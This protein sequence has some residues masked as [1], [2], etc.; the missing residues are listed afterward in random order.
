MLGQKLQNAGNIGQEPHVK[1]AVGFVKHHNFD[2]RQ[3][4]RALLHMVEQPTRRCR[5][6]LHAAPEH[7][8][9]RPNIDA[10]INH[11]G[12]QRR[13]GTVFNE[14]VGNLIRKFARGSQNECPNRMASR[15]HRSIRLGQNARN[16]RQS[17]ACCLPCPGLCRAH[18]I[19]SHEH[20]R[21]SFFLNRRWLGVAHTLNGRK[22]AGIET[23][24]IERRH[25]NILGRENAG[26]AKPQNSGHTRNRL[27]H[28]TSKRPE[29]DAEG[30]PRSEQEAST[31]D[32][33]C[34]R[35]PRMN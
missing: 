35:R 31:D 7:I 25:P 13:I 27:Q 16:E 20:H 10:P 24:L 4:D 29:R 8:G 6:D 22:N 14:I 18:H 5:E 34:S 2:L 12:A 11:A 32:R 15:R 19:A 28:N 3:I 30:L 26:T 17:I 23:E 9:L 21:N 33:C 1:H